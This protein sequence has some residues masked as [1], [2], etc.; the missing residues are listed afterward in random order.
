[1]YHRCGKV[2]V[3]LYPMRIS[4]IKYSVLSWVSLLTLVIIILVPFQGFLTVFGAH[5]IGHYTALR[6]WD[7]VLLGLCIIG[8]LYLLL[9][10]QKIRFNTLSRRLVWLIL[11]YMA[12]TL[13]WGL[14]AYGSH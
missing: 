12:L 5:L 13:V 4:A 14:I 1:M 11:I 6:L 3:T 7:E 9:A 10:D 8:T 2:I